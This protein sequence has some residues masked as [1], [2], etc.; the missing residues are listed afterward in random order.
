MEK[1]EK[2]GYYLIFFE[3]FFVATMASVAS[4]W[5]Y[6]Q[7]LEENKKQLNTLIFITLL[8]IF[9][10]IPVE[11]TIMRRY[12]RRNLNFRALP[13]KE[14]TLDYILQWAPIIF[15]FL[16]VAHLEI[17]GHLAEQYDIPRGS[18]IYYEMTI[19]SKW[20][21]FPSMLGCMLPR[22]IIYDGFDSFY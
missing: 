18:T 11:A 9:V 21:I 1:W 2:T 15:T 3:I 7:I 17:V 14:K 13:D 5:T 19:P 22:A 4:Y 6:S 16:G 8:V 10:L 20:I 12:G